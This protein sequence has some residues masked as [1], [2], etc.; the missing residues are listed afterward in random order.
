MSIIGC[1]PVPIKLY[2]LKQAAGYWPVGYGLA[3]LCLEI[4]ISSIAEFLIF[5]PVY[6]AISLHPHCFGFVYI[7]FKNPDI[8][9]TLFK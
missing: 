5:L 4:T 9:V 2:F 7:N 3:M 8:F 1:G 6:Y